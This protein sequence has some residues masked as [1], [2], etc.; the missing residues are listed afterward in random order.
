VKI[1][2]SIDDALWSYAVAQQV[3][4]GVDPLDRATQ[5]VNE[6]CAQC[7]K[8]LGLDTMSK[9][10][11]ALADPAKLATAKAALGL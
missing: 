7:G 5:Y 2:L 8:Q 11:A 4:D 10:Q 6:Y 9:V 3:L 1:T